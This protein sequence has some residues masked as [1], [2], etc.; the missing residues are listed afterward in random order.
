MSRA[1]HL[2]VRCT[3]VDFKRYE[4]TP[5][6]IIG[7]PGNQFVFYYNHVRK[8]VPETMLSYWYAE[9]NKQQVYHFAVL[10]RRPIQNEYHPIVG[11]S[12]RLYDKHGIQWYQFTLKDEFGNSH[13][14][15]FD[16]EG[17]PSYTPTGT[18]PRV[19]LTEEQWNDHEK[20][21]I[22]KYGPAYSD[23]EKA[24]YKIWKRAE[25]QSS[26]WFRVTQTLRLVD[27]EE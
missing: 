7:P 16:Y 9:R 19:Q 8:Y 24:P 14:L 21:I 6:Y 5:K 12:M 2:E 15:L 11:I 26:E 1:Q 22:Q 27:D 20:W 10:S 4:Y 25:E 17:K 23:P 18:T 3:P 13:V